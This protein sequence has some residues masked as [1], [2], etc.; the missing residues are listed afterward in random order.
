MAVLDGGKT[1]ARLILTRRDF[2][3]SISLQNRTLKI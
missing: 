2:Y 3:F 1:A